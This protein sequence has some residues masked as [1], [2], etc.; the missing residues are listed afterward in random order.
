MA[1]LSTEKLLRRRLRRAFMGTLFETYEYL[2]VDQTGKA[3]KHCIVTAFE[4]PAWRAKHLLQEAG[5]EAEGYTDETNGAVERFRIIGLGKTKTELRQE[6]RDKY[7]APEAVTLRARAR[8]R[9]AERKKRNAKNDAAR[10]QREA[11]QTEYGF[12]DFSEI[13]PSDWLQEKSQ[14]GGHEQPEKRP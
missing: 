1:K 12:N 11:V 13:I 5:V 3:T 4:L 7:N 8:E 6:E 14:A 9:L 10:A 2:T